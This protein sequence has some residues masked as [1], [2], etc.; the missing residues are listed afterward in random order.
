MLL[1]RI[2]AILPFPHLDEVQNRYDVKW[3]RISARVMRLAISPA[4]YRVLSTL[5][6]NTS[7]DAAGIVVNPCT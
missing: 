1:V 3:L 6:I 5:Y 7:A 4:H 2:R